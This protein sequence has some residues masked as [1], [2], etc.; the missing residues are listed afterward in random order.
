MGFPHLLACLFSGP[1]VRHVFG[2]LDQVIEI[3][4]SY[5]RRNATATT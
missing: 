1:N 4:S 3:V 2:Q 5:D